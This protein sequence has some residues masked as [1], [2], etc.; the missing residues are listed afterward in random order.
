MNIN[1]NRNHRYRTLVMNRIMHSGQLQ[2]YARLKCRND[3]PL[4]NH[5]TWKSPKRVTFVAEI[6]CCSSSI[7]L[8]ISIISLQLVRGSNTLTASSYGQR[9]ARRDAHHSENRC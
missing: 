1:M 4:M 5:R 7:Q 9:V 6:G 3:V 2:V 8:G